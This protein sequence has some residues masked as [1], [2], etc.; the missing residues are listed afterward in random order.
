MARP[1]PA[2]RSLP[3]LARAHVYPNGSA[4]LEVAIQGI[5]R[6]VMFTRDQVN[7]LKEKIAAFER[8][9]AFEDGRPVERLQ[10]YR[11]AL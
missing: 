11:E 4:F 3:I 5:G 10:P 6:D 2:L 8:V 7:E 1:A 9:V